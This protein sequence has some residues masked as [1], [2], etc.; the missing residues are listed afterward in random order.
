MK[1]LFLF[2]MTIFILAGVITCVYAVVMES[3]LKNKTNVEYIGK[4]LETI[5]TPNKDKIV[6]DTTQIRPFVKR[7]VSDSL[8]WTEYYQSSFTPIKDFYSTSIF[9]VSKTNDLT[10]S[11][12]P[13][14]MYYI[15]FLSLYNKEI[16]LNRHEEHLLFKT[17]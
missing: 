12:T 15:V 9:S 8:S 14:N 11:F 16:K 5:S 13:T 6:F 3:V 4:S 7:I 17:S 2:G 10:F 1:K